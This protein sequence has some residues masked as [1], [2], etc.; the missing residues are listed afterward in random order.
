MNYAKTGRLIKRK[1]KAL[2]L[3]QAQFAEAVGVTPQAVS[4]WEN[5]K[6][7]PDADAQV[8]LF[9]VAGLNPVELISGLEMYDNELKKKIAFFM[10]RIDKDAFVAGMCKDEDGNDEYLNLSEY[11]VFTFNRSGDMA[12]EWIPYTEYYNVEPVPEWVDP[13]IP[14]LSP[15][16]PWKI[17]VNHGDCIFVI[18]IEILKAVGKPLSFDVIQHNENEW[19][20]FQ[21][22][23]EPE[24]GGFDIPENVYNGKW[25]GIHVFGDEFGRMLCKVMGIRRR[26]DLIEI[27]PE[28]VPSHR[29]IILYLDRAKRVNVDINF[30]DYLLPQR[31]Y[32][33]IRAEDDDEFPGNLFG[34]EDQQR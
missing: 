28:Y 11:N 14:P 4:L 21:F 1:R 9:K 32:D 26:Q 27:E 13:T 20:G 6:R 31:Q 30:Q 29:A 19:I 25:K 22:A 33:E 16:D 12:G 23:D 7:F 2:E 3:N 10:N 24:K 34:E 5:G 8:M 18:P 17:Y 15:Y